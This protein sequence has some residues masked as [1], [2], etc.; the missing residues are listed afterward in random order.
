VECFGSPFPNYDCLAHR[1]HGVSSSKPLVRKAPAAWLSCHKAR[2]ADVM[3]VT[4]GCD[5][6]HVFQVAEYRLPNVKRDSF[7]SLTW[8]CDRYHRTRGGTR[9]D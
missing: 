7:F 1:F 9:V 4:C 8:I 5:P 6:H 3:P 2:M